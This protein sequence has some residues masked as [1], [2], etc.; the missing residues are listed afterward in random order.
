MIRLLAVLVVLCGGLVVSGCDN[1]AG[2]TPS[3]SPSASSTGPIT[4][5]SSRSVRPTPSW[6]PPNYGSAKSAVDAFLAIDRLVDA[7]FRDPEK[8]PASTFNKYLSG[9]AEQLFTAA[10]A[11]ERA[12]GKA[13]RGGPSIPHISVLENRMTE[14]PPNVL[15][16]DCR[17]DDPASPLVELDAGRGQDGGVLVSI[18]GLA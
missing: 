10:L 18:R 5:S 15:L 16:S 17:T 13:Y 1:D 3:T 11:Q 6:T 2:P 14:Q 12:E 4:T 9:Q 7:A 8:I